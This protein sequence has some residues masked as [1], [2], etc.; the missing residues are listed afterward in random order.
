MKCAF[1]NSC[2][3]IHASPLENCDLVKTSHIPHLIQNKTQFSL[4][5]NLIEGITLVF[6]IYSFKLIKIIIDKY[7]QVVATIRTE[8]DKLVEDI[9]EKE[10]ESIEEATRLRNATN[11]FIREKPFAFEP[12]L[13][14]FRVRI[15]NP[16][17]YVLL[18]GPPHSTT[19]TEFPKDILS[20]S[21]DGGFMIAKSDDDESDDESL[22]SD[23]EDYAEFVYD[24][25][26]EGSG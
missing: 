19:S 11:D 12:C 13:V 15:K 20:E 14:D 25:E 23:S 7:D 22:P 21:D 5:K 16:D 24:N 18:R 17:I 3:K 6:K 2:G 9:R 26:L 8:T 4:Q 1:L 10:A